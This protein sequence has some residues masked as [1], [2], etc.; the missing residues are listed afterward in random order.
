MS[1]AVTIRAVDAAD[2]PA[3]SALHARVSGPG[4]FARSSYRVREGAAAIS[5][6][7]RVAQLGERI[8]AAVRMTP[9]RIGTTPNALLLGPL[10]V[11]PEFANRGYGRH[12]VRE[13]LEAAQAAGLGLVILVGDEAYYGRLGFVRVPAGQIRLPG[14]IDPGR[15]LAVELESGTLGSFSGLVAADIE[16]A[17]TTPPPHCSTGERAK[18]APQY[19]QAQTHRSYLCDQNHLP[20]TGL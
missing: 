4:R 14:P 7:C 3:I 15:L 11:D 12:I 5:P 10:A 17:P 9:V 20:Q 8:I 2:L 13:S 6:F 16:P 19:H 18:L 1:L